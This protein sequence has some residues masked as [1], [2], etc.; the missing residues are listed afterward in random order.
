MKNYLFLMRLS[1]V[2]LM[3]MHLNVAGNCQTL[4]IE[5]FS[6]QAGSSLTANGWNAHSGEGTN[7]VKV[8][9]SGLLF[10]GYPSSGIG[11][12]AILNNNGE[13]VNKAFTTQTSGAVFC[14]FLVCVNS[15]DSVYFLHLAGSSI[16]TT[17][18]AR[19]FIN[20]TGSSIYFGLS[21]YTEIPVFT[22]G[23]VYNTG[24][25]YLVVLKYLIVAGSSNDEVSLFI[26]VGTVP[27]TEPLIPTIG[28]VANAGQSDLTNVSAVAL[29]Q[30]STKQ[31]IIV[32]GIRVAT[33]WEDAV[34]ALTSI[35]YQFSENNPALCPVPVTDELTISNV[36][37]AKTIE[38]FD[39]TGRKVISVKTGAT[40][41]VRIP[42]NH[43]TRSLYLV[44]I[45]TTQGIKVLRF[46][47]T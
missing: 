27:A 17:Y 18:K 5:N 40:D 39:I 32:D 1:A 16:G 28:P 37:D 6:Y 46:V 20:G 12:S 47:K 14:A 36:R 30:S 19:V 22:T 2:I 3:T 45:K 24:A 23:S 9:S 8:H 10:P 29:R 25:T 13:D 31:N 41:I 21:K 35:D 44:R 4:L 11:L 7:P 33:R 15:V 43:L 26:I 34:G 38:I 42:V